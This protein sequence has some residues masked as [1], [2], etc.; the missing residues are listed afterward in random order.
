VD[1]FICLFKFYFLKR[2]SLVGSAGIRYRNNCFYVFF[3]TVCSFV[4][5]KRCH[6]YVSFTCP[7][8]DKGADSD[9]S[10]PEVCK[11]RGNDGT[12][13]CRLFL[14]LERIRVQIYAVITCGYRINFSIPRIVDSTFWD[15]QSTSMY[16][17]SLR[18]RPS[19]M[20]LALLPVSLRRLFIEN[21]IPFSF[22]VMDWAQ[23][24]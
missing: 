19:T 7:G 15:M 12:S 9:V 18:V 8:A 13:T 2:N 6:E 3:V 11:V 24:V 20:D 10:T 17:I 22:C 5:H 14:Y 21:S 16:E 23:S 1:L 4:V